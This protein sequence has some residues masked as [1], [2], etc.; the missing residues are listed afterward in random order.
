MAAEGGPARRM[1]WLGPAVIVP[2]W[3]PEG[4][5]LF[6]TTWGQPFFRN[7]RAFTLAVDGGLPSLLPYGQ[8]NHLACG[9]KG[10]KVIGRNTADPA[11]WKR[12][13]GRRAG[14]LW[15]DASG[16]G[17]IRRPA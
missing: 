9:S 7:Y 5:I 2:G 14:S 8:V 3:T 1:K 11:R 4:A 16:A 13:R 6:V 15:V 12:Y 17:E 10:A